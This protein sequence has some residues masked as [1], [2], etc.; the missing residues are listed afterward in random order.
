[1]VDRISG[2]DSLDIS[3]TILIFL[4]VFFITT[5]LSYFWYILKKKEPHVFKTLLRN[6]Y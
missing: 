3:T 6:G 2:K 4:L 1:M 5:G